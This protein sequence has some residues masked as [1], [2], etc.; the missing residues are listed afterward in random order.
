MD[1]KE[2][3][4]DLF[5]PVMGLLSVVPDAVTRHKKSHRLQPPNG[6]HRTRRVPCC[7]LSWVEVPGPR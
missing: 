6:P 3:I 2:P 1:P 4:G 5:E 7:V